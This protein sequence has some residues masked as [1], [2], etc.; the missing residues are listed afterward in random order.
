LTAANFDGVLHQM[1][2]TLKLLTFLV[3]N[4]CDGNFSALV[5]RIA[6][7]HSLL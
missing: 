2:R 7:T 5:H 1:D 4:A 6:S 3:L